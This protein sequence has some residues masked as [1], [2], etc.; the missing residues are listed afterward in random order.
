MK[1]LTSLLLPC[2]LLALAF[3]LEPTIEAMSSERRYLFELAP[4]GVMLAGL[5]ISFRFNRSRVFFVLPK[6]DGAANQIN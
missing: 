6:F 3:A 5:A 4:F 1:T 2:A